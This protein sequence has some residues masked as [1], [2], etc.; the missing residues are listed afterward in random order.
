M[1]ERYIARNPP[2][3]PVDRLDAEVVVVIPAHREVEYLAAV[4]ASLELQAHP[5][6]HVAVVV[7]GEAGDE[8]AR[9][10]N[11]QTAAIAEQF[12]H[13]TVL[14]YHSPECA[15]EP[16]KG[17]VGAAR[18]VGLDWVL[19][20]TRDPNVRLANLDADSPV[21]A[22]YLAAIRT[23]AGSA[24]LTRYAHDLPDGAAGDAIIAYETWLRYVAAGLRAAGS[25]YAYQNLGSTIVC[26]ADAYVRAAGMP[27]RAAGEDFHFIQKLHKTSG[28]LRA[29]DAMVRPSSRVS[30]RVPFGTGPAVASILRGE[31]DYSVLE[32]PAAFDAL[33]SLF[34]V[35]ALLEHDDAALAGLP[36]LLAEVLE[37]LDVHS[38][39]ARLRRN[40]RGDRFR[41][42]FHEWFDALRT[43]QFLSRHA[44][45]CGRVDAAQCVF[46]VCGIAVDL[47]PRERLIALRQR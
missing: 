47:A 2:R 15:F 12:A 38:V 29:V 18:R 21:D 44:A 1:L 14:D 22:G 10:D 4:L 43:R 23:F 45:E 25:P 35:I 34:G 46:E 6:A 19:A 9:H 26:T 28:P 30:A 31:T 13:V 20:A 11:E 41:H 27:R 39:L 32:A 16:S 40:H 7:N 3:D 42:A 17:G 33:R 5:E 36:P 37:S 24:G 8:V